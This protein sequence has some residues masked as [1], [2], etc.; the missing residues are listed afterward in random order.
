MYWKICWRKKYQEGSKRFLDFTAAYSTGRNDK[1]IE[2]LILKIYEFSRSYPD[3]EAWLDSCVKFYEIPDVKALEGSSIMKKVM[4]DIRKNLED[5]KELLIYAENVSLSPE[6]PAVYEATLEKDSQVIEELC[7]R[8]SYKKPCGSILNVKW[9]RIAAN[10]D[11]TVS[12][13]KIDLVKKIRKWSKGLKKYERP[14]FLES[15]E[16]LVEDLR[17]CAPAMEELADL[18]RLF[19]ER[20]EEQKRAPEYDRLF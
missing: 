12:E 4:T 2:D 3:S 18:V 20:F 13:E 14:V 5:A 15:P 7:N 10:K 19:A 9:A 6:G 11:K 8:A 1:K 16:E 17:V